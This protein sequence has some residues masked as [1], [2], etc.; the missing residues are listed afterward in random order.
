MR[1]F[2]VPPAELTPK[3][4]KSSKYKFGMNL[5]LISVYDLGDKSLTFDETY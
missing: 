4:A 1:L 5:V 3:F 2:H